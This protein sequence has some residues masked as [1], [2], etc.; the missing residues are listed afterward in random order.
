MRRAPGHRSPF[1]IQFRPGW[2]EDLIL[3][4]GLRILWIFSSTFP[5][6]TGWNIT[7]DITKNSEESDTC[8]YL[9]ILKD[10]FCN[11]FR[12]IYDKNLLKKSAWSILTN[13]CLGTRSG[14]KR[15][16]LIS[17]WPSFYLSFFTSYVNNAAAVWFRL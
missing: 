12:V 11:S 4:Y 3:T 17:R 2:M 15:V 8:R 14:Q 6:V 10:F 9:V 5:H 13:I 16:H 7:T 1:K